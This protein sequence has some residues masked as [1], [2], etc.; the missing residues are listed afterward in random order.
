MSNLANLV[1]LHIIVTYA[2]ALFE[3]S[4]IATSKCSL[5]YKQGFPSCI[6]LP[7]KESLMRFQ[8]SLND[9]GAR[10]LVTTYIHI[11]YSIIPSPFTRL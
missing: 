9:M 1:P 4:C 10:L 5:L 11:L 8:I 2:T 6:E 7:T 3:A